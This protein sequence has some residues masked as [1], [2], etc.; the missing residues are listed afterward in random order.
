MTTRIEKFL[1][2]VFLIV[3]SA[4]GVIGYSIRD[5]E[6]KKIVLSSQAGTVIFDHVVHV[7]QELN[8]DL[9]HHT[10]KA[11]TEKVQPCRQCH[12]AQKKGSDI[13]RAD[14]FHG[15][16]DECHDEV[17]DSQNCKMCHKLTG[18]KH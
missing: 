13:S 1:V 2:L 18:K 3:F 6:P 5:A 11:K 10:M 17:R 4:L 7:Q 9:C 16:C 15:N 14:A 12:N 8:C